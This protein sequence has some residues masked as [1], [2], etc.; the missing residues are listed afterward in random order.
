[1]LA[2]GATCHLAICHI[3]ISK[4]HGMIEFNIPD[5]SSAHCSTV[6]QRTVRALDPKAV[7]AID[8]A[9]KKVT[10]ES[11]VARVEFAEALLAAGYAPTGAFY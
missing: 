10:I 6:I 4:E 11:S 3:A 5:I 7:V 2:N 8:I 1:M 9:S